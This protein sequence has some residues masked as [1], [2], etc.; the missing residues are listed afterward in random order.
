MTHELGAVVHPLDLDGE[1]LFNRWEAWLRIETTSEAI[2]GDSRA[3]DQSWRGYW[4]D[5]GRNA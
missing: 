5:R 2:R 4:H 3:N 1:G